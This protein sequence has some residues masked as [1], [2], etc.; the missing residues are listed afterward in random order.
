[1][2]HRFVSLDFETRSTLD[3]GDVG[4]YT[5]AE[6]PTT[7]VLCLAYALP[8]TPDDIQTWVLGDVFPVPLR[9]AIADPTVYFRAWNAAFER[10]IWRLL[11]VPKYGWPAIPDNRWVCTMVLGLAAGLPGELDIAAKALR[12]PQQKDEAGHRLM[13]QVSQPRKVKSRPGELIWWDDAE[14][15]ERLY[16]YCRQDVRTE[17][18]IWDVLPPAM[19]KRERALWLLDQRIND[20]GV[21]L[22]LDLVRAAERMAV[23]ETER[24]DARMSTLT[25]GY[26]ASTTKVADLRRWVGGQLGREIPSL[27]K[28]SLAELL[29]MP[30]MPH[31]REALNLR[32]EAGKSS[33]AKYDKMLGM[34][35][36]GD[37]ARGTLQYYGAG[38]GRWA[39]RGIQ[40]QNLPK[41]MLKR[42]ELESAV[43]WVKA[44]DRR[45]LEWLYDRPLDVLATLL[46]SCIVPAPGRVLDVA[47]FSAIEA[48]VVAALAQQNDLVALF[49]SGGKVYEVM[50]AAIFGGGPEDYPK[51]SN[52]RDIAK[53]TVLGAGFGMGHEKFRATV[54]KQGGGDPGEE[55]S[56]RA[57]K[58]FRDFYPKIPQLWR[59]MD[60]TALEVVGRGLTAWREVPGTRLAFA[61]HQDYLML[62]LPVGRSLWYYHPRV[63]SRL[64]PWSTDERPV[65]RPAVQYVGLDSV[66]RQFLP[67]DAYGGLWT[68]NAVQAV[69]R[70]LMADA[71]TRID[72]KEHRIICSVHDELIVES[73]PCSSH[74]AFMQLMQHVPE[75]AFGI[76]VAAEGWRG[77][78][79]AK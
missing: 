48:R 52:E 2:T 49:A 68:E 11:C 54:V 58:T 21:G 73:D 32:Q 28:Q 34:V 12:L 33:V 16:A 56:R 18:A 39:G 53:R 64:M 37:R 27:D 76:P 77:T 4:A 31:V 30:Q 51:D 74:G 40:L 8:E 78:R 20:R 67:M 71:M 41:G 13:L 65:R 22:D 79:Y 66:T 10:T 5:Y 35:G 7:D 60:E 55:L 43:R 17:N 23:S 9:D 44:G 45:P 75:W 69:A 19:D 15:L 26:V 29:V 62:R 24:L 47:D 50:A 46:R 63:V 59:A 6:H 1:M 38:T 25:G 57:V 3:L 61:L 72:S 14:R 42:S 36:S 70:D